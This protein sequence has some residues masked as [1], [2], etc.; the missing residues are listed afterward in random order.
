M[1]RQAI[2]TL[3]QSF[4]VDR[5]MDAVLFAVALRNVLRAADFARQVTRNPKI[6]TAVQAFSS[7]VPDAV[8][9]RDQLEHFDAY[10]LGR[11]NLQASSQTQ[12][13]AR[14]PSKDGIVSP[15][16]PYDFATARPGSDVTILLG[17]YSL[18]VL[19][20]ALAAQRL[21]DELAPLLA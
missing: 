12:R 15:S 19:T 14:T 13:A 11:G 2:R 5:E 4:S 21:V 10:E 18:D 16:T 20:G 8:S 7:R 6:A 3:E 1:Q 17:D 9:I